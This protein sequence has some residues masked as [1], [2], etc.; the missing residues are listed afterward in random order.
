MLKGNI[1]GVGSIK[2]LRNFFG[3]FLIK[4]APSI[5][6]ILMRAKA[7]VTAKS[8]VGDLKPKIPIMLLNPI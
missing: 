6:I 1:I 8:F 3:R 4:A 5:R 2:L 7:M